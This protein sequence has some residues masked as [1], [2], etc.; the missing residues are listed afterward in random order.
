M[1]HPRFPQESAGS[2]AACVVLY[3]LCS[4]CIAVSPVVSPLHQQAP[5]APR[6]TSRQQSW[7]FSGRAPARESSSCSSLEAPAL[8]ASLLWP[9]QLPSM[10]WRKY[11]AA[12]LIDRTTDKVEM[13]RQVHS[14]ASSGPPS[15]PLTLSAVAIRLSGHTRLTQ[16]AH[17]PRSWRA[18]PELH[19]EFLALWKAGLPK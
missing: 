2:R 18:Y 4:G 19:A 14:I 10:S 13:V 3:C 7:S 16:R 9:S 17:R 8:G 6:S 11:G 12:E 5:R 15:C 1:G